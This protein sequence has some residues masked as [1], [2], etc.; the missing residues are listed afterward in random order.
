MPPSH[1]HQPYQNPLPPY[2]L[3][4]HNPPLNPSS[5]TPPTHS[6][7]TLNKHLKFYLSLQSKHRAIPPPATNTS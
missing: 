6:Q 1:S 5:P 7:N 3:S 4:S 2:P